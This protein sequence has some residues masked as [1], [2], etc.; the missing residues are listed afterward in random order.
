MYK[1]EIN[2]GLVGSGFMGKTHVFGYAIAEKVFNLPIKFNM[3]KVAD[4]NLNKAKIAKEN[5]GFRHCTEDWRELVDDKEIDLIDITVPNSM[6]KD[7]ALAAIDSGKHVYCEKPLAPFSKDALEMTKAAEDKKIKTQVGFNYLVNPMFSLAKDIINS[8]E[9]GEIYNF[10]GIHAEDYMSDK[11]IEF[12]FRHEKEGGGVLSD[13]GSH[14]VATAEFLLGPIN[15]VLGD[16]NT[17]INKRKD[18]L[19]NVKNIEVDDVTN[20][21]LKFKNGAV[22]TLSANWCATGKKMQHDFEVF[23]SKGSIKFSQERLNELMI[24]NVKDNLKQRGYK[25]IEAGPEHFPYGNFCVAPGHQ[26]GFNDLKAI[27]IA[28]FA[29]SLLGK[30]EKFNF[31]SGYR[32]QKIVESIL[33][34]SKETSWLT[35]PY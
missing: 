2:V 20:C 33:E 26:L 15:K 5:F 12:S 21:F 32:I 8:G 31:R 16:C 23:G 4:I 6:H 18:N 30:K 13:L 3:F 25:K 19:G 1:K 17:I 34:S 29:D 24:Y 10:I 28:Y 7:I 11:N 22:G 14:V 9:L 27:E 35:I